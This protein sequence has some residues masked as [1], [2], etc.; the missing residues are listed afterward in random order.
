MNAAPTV[1]PL[2]SETGFE[3]AISCCAAGVLPKAPLAHVAAYKAGGF[4]YLYVR[5]R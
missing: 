5:T 2:E 4:S 1:A 3:P